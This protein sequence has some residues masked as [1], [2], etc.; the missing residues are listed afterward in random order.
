M[1]ASVRVLCESERHR[2]ETRKCE[3]ESERAP[4]ESRERTDDEKE[5]IYSYCKCD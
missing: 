1:R 4:S 2:D 3:S 5:E